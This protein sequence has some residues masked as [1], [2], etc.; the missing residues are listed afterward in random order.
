MYTL[1]LLPTVCDRMHLIPELNLQMHVTVDA[2]S[3]LLRA[4]NTVDDRVSKQ[5][6]S[7]PSASQRT[8]IQWVM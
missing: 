1:C 4:A 3:C 8:S 7:Y 6:S 5:I 2:K